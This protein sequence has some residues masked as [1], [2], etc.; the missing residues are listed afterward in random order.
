VAYFVATWLLQ[1]VL[2]VATWLLRGGVRQSLLYHQPS[3]RFLRLLCQSSCPAPPC[4]VC[5]RHA[6]CGTWVWGS[7]RVRCS[8]FDP[9]ADLYS[10]SFIF[11]E[12]RSDCPAQAELPFNR[13]CTAGC[14]LHNLWPV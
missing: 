3:R 6:L 11:A 1:W 5:S 10:L 12:V 14:C 7:M 9:K 8:K 13:A 2:P 4:S